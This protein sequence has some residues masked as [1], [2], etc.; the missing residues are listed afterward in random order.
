MNTLLKWIEN[1]FKWIFKDWK[2]ILFVFLLGSLAVLS[3][4]YYNLRQ[5]YDNIVISTNDSMTTYKNKAG[6]LYI[7]NQTYITDIKHLKQQNTELYNE[8]KNLK[9]NPIVVTKVVTKTEFK[10][11][12]ITDTVRIDPSGN[13]TFN[14][15]YHDQWCD[16]SGRSSFDINSM[17]GTAKFDSISFPNNITIDLIEKNKQLSFIAKSDNPYCQINSLKGSILSP[18]NSSVLKK[19]FEKKWYIVYGI[20]PTVS[21][22]DNKIIIVPGLQVT[23]GR[24]LFAF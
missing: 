6:E 23:F 11:K 24:K 21:V 22:Y 7:Q 16:L 20:G 15:Q 1:L 14:M 9:D 13:Y 3:F 4:K 2:H 18:E 17:I 10:D 5:D 12:I 19:R 8:V